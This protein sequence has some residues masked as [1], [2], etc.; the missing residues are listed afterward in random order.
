MDSI[1]HAA[2][3][4]LTA[5]MH[6]VALAVA[7][8]AGALFLPL[9]S[10][11][12]PANG[13]TAPDFALKDLAGHNQRLSEFRGDVVVLTFWASWC[14]PCRGT[15]ESVGAAVAAAEGAP[16]ALG[17]S[18]D[19]DAVRASSVVASLGLRFPSLLD[20]DQAVGRLYDVQHLP[21]TLLIDRE[22]VVRQAWTRDPVP[23]DVLIQNI[24][25]LKP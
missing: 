2:R 17:V 22:G 9:I 16:A 6:T 10:H 21:L 1:D 11:A 8:L 7:A 13:V 20:A 25:E 4:R 18:L 14:G 23:A 15:L 12:A 19:H 3:A 24:R 5:L